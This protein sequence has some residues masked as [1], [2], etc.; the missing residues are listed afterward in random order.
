MQHPEWKI[1][2]RK[3]YASQ[4]LGTGKEIVD[5]AGGGELVFADTLVTYWGKI[6]ISDPTG[7]K[8]CVIF[9]AATSVCGP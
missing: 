1:A 5:E 3:K 9:I 2:E 6:V 7:R 4:R 8:S